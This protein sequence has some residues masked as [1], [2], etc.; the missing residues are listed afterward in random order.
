MKLIQYP[1]DCHPKN[2]E[3]MRRMCA[4]WNIEYEA[5]NDK[6]KCNDPSVTILWLPMFWV[7]PD[8]FPG[9]YILYG[10]HHSVFPQGDLVGPLNPEWSKRC[11][12]TT[13]SD[14]NLEVFKEFAHE[15]VIPIA[16]LSFGISPA[17]EDCTS[18]PKSLDCI[19]Y[20]KRRNP[21]YIQHAIQTLQQLNLTYKVFQYGSYQNQEYMNALKSTKL[22]IWIGTHESQGFAFQECLASNVPILCWDATT[23]F[24][25]LQQNSQPVYEYLRGQKQLKSTTATQ[26][27]PQC[28]QIIYEQDQ[29]RPAIEQML[30]TYINYIPRNFILNKCSDT[31]TMRRIL[32]RFML[33]PRQPVHFLTFATFNFSNALRRIT[34]EAFSFAK[35]TNIHSINESILKQDTEFWSTHQSFIESN[36]RGFGYWIWKPYLLLKIVKQAQ[37]GDIVVYADSGCT[38][39]NTKAAYEKFDLYTQKLQTSKLGI[40]AFSNVN[41]WARERWLTKMDV[42]HKL[43]AE[44]LLHTRQINATVIFIRKCD[45]SLTILQKWYDLCCDYSN[46]DDTQSTIPNHPEFDDHR[47]D[48]SVFSILCKLYGIEWFHDDTD[49][50]NASHP[51]CATR[52]RT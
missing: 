38:L 51:I 16:P 30:N 50:N 39:Y 32:E 13:L 2:R 31:N 1:D 3:S 46:I 4:V 41:E 42:L 44:H 37:D 18:Y 9:K 34:R 49:Q 45:T 19:I 27:S 6:S 52:Q 22:C 23:M 33:I 47:H 5:T 40:M 36:P 20:F 10:P 26:W 7:S 35:F 14:W 28:G 24:E 17:I 43:N 48:Q 25:E 29:L 11:V 12:Y 21:A 15:T 8:E